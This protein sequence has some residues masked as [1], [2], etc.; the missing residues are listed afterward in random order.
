MTSFEIAVIIYGVLIAFQAC[1]AAVLLTSA[2]AKQV[3]RVSGA[4][5][6]VLL[7]IAPVMIALWLIREFNKL[8]RLADFGN[9]R[10]TENDYR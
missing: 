2:D 7:P 10:N 3:H 6:M 5:L 9:K 1:M 8:I 4:R